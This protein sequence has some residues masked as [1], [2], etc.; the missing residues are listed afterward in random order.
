MRIR[1]PDLLTSL[2]VLTKGEY[3]RLGGIWKETFVKQPKL[4]KRQ[5]W[6]VF[7]Q[8]EDIMRMRLLCRDV[9]PV[10]MSRWRID[11]GRVWFRVEKRF[12]TSLIM[13]GA[14]ADDIWAFVHVEFLF[15]VPEGERKG[16]RGL[17]FSLAD[18]PRTHKTS[19]VSSQ[20]AQSSLGRRRVPDS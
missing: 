4:S 7:K 10:E 1:N 17:W 8:V 18:I 13:T 3:T 9:V 2:D 5:V 12:E 16:S 15:G 11:N 19:R 20:T 14:Q 6:E